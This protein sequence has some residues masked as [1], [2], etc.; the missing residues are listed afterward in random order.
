MKTVVIFGGSGFVGR[1]IIRRIAKK[2]YKIIVPY[3]HPIDEAKIRLFG[4][5]GQIVPIRFN[6]IDETIILR[7]LNYSEIII[8]LKT[9]WD[10]KKNTYDKGIFAFNRKLCDIIKNNNKNAQF[11]YFSGLGV[12]KDHSSK[13]S[14]S[15]LESEIYFKE[16]LNNL[17][18]V[19][20][21]VILG[22]GDQFLKN[23]FPLFKMSFFIPLFGT[24]KSRFQPVYID[25]VSRA[26]S[27]VDNQSLLGIH[28]FEFFGN[29]IFSYREFYKLIS[30]YSRKK[31]YLIPI[32]LKLIKIIVYILEKISIS[33]LKME[34][35]KL[36]EKD[37]VAGNIGK[38]LTNL[39]VIPQ[40]L[41]EILKKI[42]A[43]NL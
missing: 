23:L 38:N 18:I 8:N 6:S 5:T 26:I 22:G 9:Q 31:R 35:L 14:K 17:V 7:L 11:I 42:I 37:N 36:F 32:P 40:D 25:D 39:N 28:L 34:Q 20:P 27:E 4:T 30:V 2:G 33:P 15:I 21:G 19:R 13:R 1:H 29:Q 12:D 16:N 43:K 3:Q 24:G 41:T 10:E